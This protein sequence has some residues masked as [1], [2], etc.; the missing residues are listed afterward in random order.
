MSRGVA[1]RTF[2][3]QAAG[4]SV[5]RMERF[6]EL[7]RWTQPQ[8]VV[9]YGEGD[10]LGRAQPPVRAWKF[11]GSHSDE[12]EAFTFFVDETTG[13]L[14]HA[15]NTGC[16]FDAS[17]AR[18]LHPRARLVLGYHGSQTGESFGT[19]LRRKVRLGLLAGGHFTSV[20]GAGG[21]QLRDRVG[22]PARRIDVLQNGG[23]L[24]RFVSTGVAARRAG[25]RR[26]RAVDR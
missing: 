16:W 25:H 19:R 5:Q 24:G 3:A 23:E 12:A 21:R 14:I 2:R 6:A 11:T 7:D 15:R 26:R 1:P 10:D 22:V 17:V 13:E 18:I 4:A 8:L 20:S 9:Y